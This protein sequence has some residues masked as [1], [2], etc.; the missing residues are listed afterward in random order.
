M[1]RDDGGLAATQRAAVSFFSFR[2]SM[3]WIGLV[4]RDGKLMRL[5]LPEVRKRDLETRMTGEWG[6]LTTAPLP[7]R[8]ITLKKTLES[9][10]DGARVDPARTRAPL[11]FEGVTPFR[12]RIYRTL[13]G[14][15]RGAVT[16][17]G[18]LARMAG[19]PGAARGVGTAMAGNPYPLVVP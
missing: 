10:Y 4:F 2:T 18:V 12:E 9:F 3:G 6:R 17:Y 19:S 16:T 11:C 8:L 13:R 14:V 7:P 5:A 1:T 15:P